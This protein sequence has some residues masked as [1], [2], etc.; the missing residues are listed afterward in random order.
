[1]VFTPCLW[2]TNAH[3]Y[4]HNHTLIQPL[5]GVLWDE[6]HVNRFEWKWWNSAFLSLFSLFGPFRL[7]AGA[8]LWLVTDPPAWF[9]ARLRVCV[10]MCSSLLPNPVPLQPRLELSSPE[11]N[12]KYK[13]KAFLP[14][15]WSKHTHIHTHYTC[16]LWVHHERI[17]GE[18][19]REAFCNKI[20]KSFFTEELSNYRN[21]ETHLWTEKKNILVY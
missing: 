3:T 15:H 11:G 18:W 10:F 7:L 1:M 19:C 17:Y 2:G 13:N 16:T 6:F 20:L 9:G 4:V 14:E 8:G 21:G 12:K 5:R